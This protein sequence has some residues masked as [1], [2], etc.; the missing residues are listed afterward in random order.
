MC[1]SYQKGGRGGGGTVPHGTVP[2]VADSRVLLTSSHA[3]RLLPWAIWYVLI[4]FATPAAI[5]PLPLGRGGTVTG[6]AFPRHSPTLPPGIFNGFPA[7]SLLLLGC[8]SQSIVTKLN[9]SF[10]RP[11]S[12]SLLCSLMLTLAATRPTFRAALRGPH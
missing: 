8:W 11:F 10:C 6:Q 7:S 3:P 1:I 9:S 2:H 12:S 5:K 4:T